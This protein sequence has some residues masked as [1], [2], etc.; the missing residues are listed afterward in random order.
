MFVSKKDS[1]EVKTSLSAEDDHFALV[2]PMLEAFCIGL[3]FNELSIPSSPTD[4]IFGKDAIID[5]SLRLDLHQL[6]FAS[7]NA[8]Q[9][10]LARYL[11]YLAGG[12]LS[13]SDVETDIGIV[14]DALGFDQYRDVENLLTGKR[15]LALDWER[16]LV[17]E[18]D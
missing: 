14:R 7:E 16:L 1:R 5:D 4:A 2:L 6:C 12:T 9:C 13:R 8:N 11:L 3:E 18:R 10:L 15:L 17:R